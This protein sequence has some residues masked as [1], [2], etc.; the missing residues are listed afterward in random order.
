MVEEA[1][2]KKPKIFKEASQNLE[3]NKTMEEEI[4]A[5]K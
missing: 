5:L 2:A 1:D 3:W 4:I